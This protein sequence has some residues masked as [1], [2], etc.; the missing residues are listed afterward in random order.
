M[1]MHRATFPH[2]SALFNTAYI[3][4]FQTLPKSAFICISFSQ[5]RTHKWLLKCYEITRLWYF[6][7]KKNTYSTQECSLSWIQFITINTFSDFGFGIWF[8]WPQVTPV[9]V[10]AVLPVILLGDT[11]GNVWC[12]PVL[13]GYL[14]YCQNLIV[15][16][17]FTEGLYHPHG[18]YHICI[19]WLSSI[20][21]IRTIMRMWV[22][23]C[24]K[25]IFV[26][27]FELWIRLWWVR[28]RD[29]LMRD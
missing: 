8:S 14:R 17:G 27:R 26:L 6:S 12:F 3:L 10:Y 2:T 1:S 5:V 13:L 4:Y 15:L 19:V 7:S 29:A 11:S 20:V 22:Y 24:L 28:K 16:G 25:L 23:G 18:E 9:L 21:Y